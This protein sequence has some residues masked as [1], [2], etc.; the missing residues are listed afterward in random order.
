MQLMTKEL[1][2]IIPPLYS[3]EEIELSSKYL[4]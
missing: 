4:I 1:E 3:S 2:K